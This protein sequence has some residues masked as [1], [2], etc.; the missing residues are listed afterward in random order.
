MTERA[1]HACASGTCPA[2]S[3]CAGSAAA[4]GRARPRPPGPGAGGHRAERGQ[5]ERCHRGADGRVVFGADAANLLLTVTV[6]RQAAPR[7]RHRGVPAAG[8]V[9]ADGNVIRMTKRRP[10]AVQLDLSAV[11]ERL[12]ALLPGVHA[13][14]AA[15]SERGPDRGAGGPAAA[16][17]AAGAAQRRAAGDQPRRDGALQRAVGGA[18]ADQPR[19]RRAVPRAGREV[20]AAAG[21][22]GVQGPVLGQRQPRAAHPAELDHR[23]DPAAGR[24]GQA[25]SAPSSGT[26]SG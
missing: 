21:R 8:H 20:R 4:G 25:A 18:G 9:Q 16:A 6:E 2:S 19:R 22:V 17:G 15:T 10:P 5:P 7:G 14:R 13:G 12:A 11:R 1:R 24:A 26:R 3:P 23:A